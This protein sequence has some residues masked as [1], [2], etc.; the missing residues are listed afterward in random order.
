M[1]RLR[2][3]ACRSA[4]EGER[5]ESVA[6]AKDSE[7]HSNCE[8]TRLVGEG[9]KRSVTAEQVAK[10]ADLESVVTGKDS[11]GICYILHILRFMYFILGIC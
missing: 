3:E 7:G 10:A 6:L 9:L 11:E 1:N 4:S 8:A 2:F 5:L